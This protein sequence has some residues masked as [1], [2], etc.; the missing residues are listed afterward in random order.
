MTR[1]LKSLSSSL[2][3]VGKKPKKSSHKEWWQLEVTQATV[4]TSPCTG[5]QSQ[6]STGPELARGTSH[7]IVQPSMVGVCAR[8]QHAHGPTDPRA[9]RVLWCLVALAKTAPNWKTCKHPST[10]KERGGAMPL[11]GSVG[12]PGTVNRKIRDTGL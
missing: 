9:W 10:E 4:L 6:I 1:L 2:E 12:A 11:C 5:G 3:W 8:Q 7:S